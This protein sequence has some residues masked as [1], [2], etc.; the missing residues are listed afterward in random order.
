M[1]TSILAVGTELTSG[2]IV[3]TN[4]AF[5]SR[6]LTEMG[7][8]VVLHLT[9]SDD[10]AAIMSA[11]RTCEIVS[12]W[13][14]VTGG[15]GPTTDDFTRDVVAEWTGKKNFFDQRAW[16]TLTDK[17]EKRGRRTVNSQ[18]QQCY[19]PE[20][21]S[22]LSNSKGTAEAFTLEVRGRRIWVLPG[23]PVEVEAVWNE[24]IVTTIRRAIP[25]GP[26]DRLLSWVCKGK[27]ES[28]I[29]E[30]I[31]KIVKGTELRT[32]YRCFSPFVE[33]K[34]WCPREKVKDYADRFALIDAELQ[35]CLES[36]PPEL[37]K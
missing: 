37:R 33:V 31:E 29:G 13:I 22:V 7:A 34:L 5:L 11:L 16:Q 15:L 9:V 26:R 12:D 36:R 17:L 2:Q 28:E 6:V 14:F 35:D 21:S 24:E 23:P 8:E 18:R 20:G 19:F 25:N 1:K 30:I 32:G 3:N 10:R 27:P 4:A